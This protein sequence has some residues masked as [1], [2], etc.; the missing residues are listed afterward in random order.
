MN[1]EKATTANTSTVVSNKVSIKKYAQQGGW[2]RAQD[3]KSGKTDYPAGSR[4][5]FVIVEV[6]E[7]DNFG[8]DVLEIKFADP[9]IF[10]ENAGN[11]TKFTCNTS[12][13]GKL[14]S[15]MTE[16][17]DGMID[18]DS[19]VGKTCT[20]VSKTYPLFD[21]K[22]NK[23]ITFESKFKREGEFVSFQIESVQETEVVK[24]KSKKE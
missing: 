13:S 10:Q 24:S 4:Y 6:K 23:E 20:L 12:N 21:K 1:N 3:Q 9:K 2:I 7:R 18:L 11:Y 19:I 14:C 8:K 22:T 15:F 17:K 5:S 16:D